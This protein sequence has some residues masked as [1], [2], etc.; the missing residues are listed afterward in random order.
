MQ[1]DKD[2]DKAKVRTELESSKELCQLPVTKDA[3]SI[4]IREGQASC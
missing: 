2:R 1:P 3:C 4:L